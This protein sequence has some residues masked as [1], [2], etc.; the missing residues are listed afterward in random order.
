MT[1]LCINGKTIIF[2]AFLFNIYIYILYIIFFFFVFSFGKSNW[3][4]FKYSLGGKNMMLAS[5]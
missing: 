3:K 4:S 1:D 2:L 5:A